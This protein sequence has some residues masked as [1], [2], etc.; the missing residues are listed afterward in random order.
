MLHHQ[1][2][3]DQTDA[4]VMQALCWVLL[5][6]RAALAA[7]TAGR[8]VA[9]L[10]RR[11]LMNWEAEACG[12]PRSAAAHNGA[13][14]FS[15]LAPRAAL[16]AALCQPQPTAQHAAWA[17]RTRGDQ[18]PAWLRAFAAAGLP[19]HTELAMPALSP[20][21]SQGNLLEWKKQEGEAVAAGDVYCEVETD[22]ATMEW[23]AQEDGFLA[24]IL[25]AAG[26]KDIAVGTPV[27]IVVEDEG[28]EST[29][30]SMVPPCPF[31]VSFAR[32]QP[33]ATNSPRPA[34]RCGRFQ[35]L[36]AGR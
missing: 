34:R 5:P 17:L 19:A 24:K 25:V 1:R 22:K 15:A 35:G 32:F 23:E 18:V 6:A 13:R 14:A 9:H 33:P 21:M 27:A 12:A 16:A 36:R 28:G 8:R 3:C 10:G 29:T 11:V 2:A 30:V 20:T 7:M 26:T 4:S 31:T